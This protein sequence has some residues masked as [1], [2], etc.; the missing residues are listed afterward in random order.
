MLKIYLISPRK[1]SLNIFAF[2]SETPQSFCMLSWMND[3]RVYGLYGTGHYLDLERTLSFHS[4]NYFVS[5][6]YWSARQKRLSTIIS[7]SQGNY[8][9]WQ[10][11]IFSIKNTFLYQV[12]KVLFCINFSILW[13][14][15]VWVQNI[16]IFY[17]YKGKRCISLFPLVAQPLFFHF[18]FVLPS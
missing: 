15:H 5:L 13:I 12:L 7:I 9:I 1:K 6:K 16:G 11:S 8:H 3:F 10:I 4:A 2:T 17:E 18:D 14:E